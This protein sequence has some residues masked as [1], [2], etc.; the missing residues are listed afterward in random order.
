MQ[1]GPQIRP[2][3]KFWRSASYVLRPTQ[4]IVG[5]FRDVP[6]ANLVAWYGKHN[7]QSEEMYYNTKQTQN[8]NSSGDEIANVKCLRRQ[9][10]CRG[11][12]LRPLNRLPNLYVRV[13]ASLYYTV[14]QKLVLERPCS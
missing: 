13:P 1:C 14:S 9:R 10:K 12:R 3:Q 2:T 4:H 7:H 6:Q 11:Q 5:H 8:K